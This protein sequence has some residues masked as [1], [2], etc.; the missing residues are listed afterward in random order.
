MLKMLRD[1]YQFMALALIWIM[2]AVFAGP[3]V[4]AL[5][6]LSILFIRSR[7]MWPEMFFGFLLVLVLSDVA[8]DAFVSMNVFKS[9][10]NTYIVV[11]AVVFFLHREHFAPYARVF[12]LFLPFFLFSIIPLIFSN[13]ILVGIQKT[14][15]YALLYL[16]VPNFVLYNFRRS[17]WEFIRNLIW[18]M[19]V[20]LL[21]GLVT[22]LYGDW[23]SHV[24]GRFRGLFGNP[25]GLGIFCY[26]T[27]V[28]VTVAISIN[29]GL[30]AFYEKAIIYGVILYFLFSSGSRAS[31]TAVL[32][33]LVFHR[34]VA[35]SPSL[36]F[37]LFLAALGVGEVVSSNLPAIVE[38]L[39]LEKYFR[40]R[41]LESGSGRYFAWEFAWI[42]IQD[43]FVLGGGFGN[44]E[45]IFRKHRF[46]LW[47][48]NHQG[49]VH[50]S[51]LSFWLDVGIVGLLIYLR[52]FLLM[53]I[54]AS[55]AVP[56]SLAVM[57]STLFSIM[58]E[59]W[60]VGSLNPFTIV[61]LTTMTLV[62]EEE[63]YD[64]EHLSEAD[65]ATHEASDG[66][67]VPALG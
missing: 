12:D 47:R 53:F 54:K 56:M 39:G 4:F 26:L 22:Y 64:W 57:F 8:K 20:I 49:G 10:K 9:A 48:M 51:Y 65:E 16:I 63:I 6:P 52:S 41:T 29:R 31:T 21:A 27:L 55:K 23:Y 59:S 30:F 61:L 28:L 67:V 14:L 7:E 35:R 5:L 46:Y 45:F 66:E 15:S 25:N 34:L 2:A 44:D 1:E 11:L 50:N 58:Y 40:L 3:I 17:G 33:F 32:I 24:N 42:H 60:L 18:F 19:V 37:V 13:T 36:G 62:T 43:Y 38:A